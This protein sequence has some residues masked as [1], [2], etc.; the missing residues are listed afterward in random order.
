MVNPPPPNGVDLGL[1]I[2]STPGIGTN[3]TTT[4]AKNNRKIQ[5]ALPLDAL[6]SMSI[7]SI[8]VTY[9]FSP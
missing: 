9:L 2:R 4:T 7:A 5:I 6:S 8:S 3:A 1:G